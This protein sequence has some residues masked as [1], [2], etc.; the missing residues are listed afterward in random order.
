[1]ILVFGNSGQVA[2]ELQK[3]NNVIALNRSQADLNDLDSCVAAIHK[4][5]PTGVINA[6]AYTAVDLAEDNEA[7]ATQVNGYAPGIIARSCEKLCIPLVH[8]STDYVFGDTSNV[9]WK[10]SDMTSP[11]NAY[12][13]SKLV[14]EKEIIASGA[15][16]V[17]LRTSW[18]V[19]SSGNNFLKTMLRL[20]ET[21]DSLEIVADQIGG[22][23]PA[24]NIANVCL[25]I[26]TQ[27]K[28]NPEKAGI[29]H[30]SGSP[31]VSW[32]EFANKIFSES[33]LTTVAKPIKTS[34]YKTRAKRMLN[35]RLDCGKI[36]NTFDIE[37]PDWHSELKNILEELGFVN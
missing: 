16:S 11:L 24:S 3:Y 36:L 20:S 7:I 1:M 17:I 23:T 35:S 14:G 8:I 31:D 32:C 37:R 22:P 10:T 21:R 2:T 4:Y 30:F 33:G 13:R 26:I 34:H 19:S 6:A 5:Q 25:D 9:P 29:Y 18:V 28:R 27:L 15:T 12:G